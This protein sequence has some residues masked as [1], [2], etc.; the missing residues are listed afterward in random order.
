ME[1]TA[2]GNR[3]A[4]RA[5]RV[6]V[7][8]K[9]DQDAVEQYKQLFE[10]APVAYHEL[11][12]EG[13][14]QRVSNA[15][16][17]L[18][19][20]SREEMLGKHICEFV[21][22]YEKDECLQ[23]FAAKV[24]GQL[25]VARTLRYY[26]T[27]S[28]R[29]IAVEIYDHLIRDPSGE[30]IGIRSALIDVTTQVKHEAALKENQLWLDSVFQSIPQAIVILDSLGLVK[31]INPC[32]ENLLEWSAPALLGKPLL[33]MTQTTTTPLSPDRQ[34]Y[35]PRFGVSESWEGVSTF[36]TEHNELKRLFVKTV[37]LLTEDEVCIGIALTFDTLD[38]SATA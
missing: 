37:P 11:N 19:E 30:I 8:L 5:R 6:T 3:K 31:Q 18:L 23:R 4:A 13:V 27:K 28:N 33:A 36:L 16:C 15:E 34:P 29:D 10:E 12:V 25:P 32:A 2:E 24:R 35:S 20:Y 7:M 9:T 17:K 26:R 22:P 21:A 1:A 38:E 14:V